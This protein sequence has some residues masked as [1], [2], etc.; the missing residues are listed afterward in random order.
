MTAN[1]AS[2]HSYKNGSFCIINYFEISS[3]VIDTPKYNISHP[4][5]GF[6]DDDDGDNDMIMQTKTKRII[7]PFPGGF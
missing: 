3:I 4:C 5:V 6:E 1:H 7:W 2:N